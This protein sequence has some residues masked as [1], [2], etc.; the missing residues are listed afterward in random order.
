MDRGRTMKNLFGCLTAAMLAAGTVNAAAVLDTSILKSGNTWVYSYQME[1]RN[2]T[3]ASGFTGLARFTIVSLE[4]IQDTV[5]FTVSRRDSGQLLVWAVGQSPAVDTTYSST[6]NFRGGT[7]T[8]T[9][10]LFA[11][12]QTFSDSDQNVVYRGDT[13][14]AKSFNTSWDFGMPCIE[15][16]TANIQGI[17]RVTDRTIRNPCGITSGHT[18]YQL[19][20]Y[21][22]VPYGADS[23]YAVSIRAALRHGFT[24]TQTSSLRKNSVVFDAQ[25]VL[26]DAKGRKAAAVAPLLQ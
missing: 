5:R 26:F 23:V 21:N 3:V 11:M 6:F 10:P 25:G 7:Y 22:G 13:V 9:V 14:R 20:R 8:P 19:I 4:Q 17:G 15:Q 18:N 1:H 2:P 12:E 24:R 16:Q